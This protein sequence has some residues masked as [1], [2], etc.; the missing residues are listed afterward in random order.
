MGS[1]DEVHLIGYRKNYLLI[2][3]LFNFAVEWIPAVRNK[4]VLDRLLGQLLKSCF[5]LMENVLKPLA[6]RLLMHSD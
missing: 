3:K 1:S 4:A 6:K 2:Y 5:L